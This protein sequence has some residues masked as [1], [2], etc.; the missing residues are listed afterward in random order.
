MLDHT[1][2]TLCYTPLKTCKIAMCC[3]ILHNFCVR[4]NIPLQDVNE[5]QTHQHDVPN[6]LGIN[7]NDDGG[8]SVRQCIVSIFG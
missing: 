4:R 3:F 1:G 6:D 8:L 7:S 2:G 5:G